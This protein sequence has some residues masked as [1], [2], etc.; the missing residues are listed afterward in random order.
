MANTDLTLLKNE[1]VFPLYSRPAFHNTRVHTLNTSPA[2][3]FPG[4]SRPPPAFTSYRCCTTPPSPWERHW[5]CLHLHHPSLCPGGLHLETC[6][7]WGLPCVRWHLGREGYI[8]SIDISVC[9]ATDFHANSVHPGILNPA[10]FT[11]WFL[12]WFWNFTILTWSSINSLFFLRAV[13]LMWA[14]RMGKKHVLQC[15]QH[16]W[17][18]DAG[19]IFQQLWIFKKNKVSIST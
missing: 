13:H 7:P 4:T 9:Y 6:P 14:E 17:Y 1:H 18:A 16:L 10:I 11:T 5:C 15:L 3:T 8:V 19:L 12:T 2:A